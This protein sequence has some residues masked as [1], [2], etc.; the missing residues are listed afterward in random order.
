[1]LY[2]MVI[3]LGVQIILEFFE[4]IQASLRK[5]TVQLAKVQRGEAK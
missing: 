1:M 2:S 3:V 5:D 4:Q